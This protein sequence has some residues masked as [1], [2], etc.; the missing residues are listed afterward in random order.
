MPPRCLISPPTQV[1]EGPGPSWGRCCRPAGGPSAPPSSSPSPAGPSAGPMG[2]VES[3][4][5]PAEGKDRRR[6]RFV[7][8]RLESLRKRLRPHGGEGDEPGD[9]G[10]RTAHHPPPCGRRIATLGPAEPPPG[11]WSSWSGRSSPRPASRPARRS[12]PPP[13]PSWVKGDPADGMWPRLDNTLVC[14]QRAA[15]P[16]QL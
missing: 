15:P 13:G 10:P 16:L 1:R 9:V 6:L 5:E 12:R 14:F 7:G 2:S 11:R 8:L 4:N 3:G